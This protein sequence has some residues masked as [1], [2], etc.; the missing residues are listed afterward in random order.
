M[1]LL[2]YA[3]ERFNTGVIADV[4][5][6]GSMEDTYIISQDLGIE[7]YLKVSLF[8]VIDGHGGDYCAHYLR[9][10]LEDELRT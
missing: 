4:G 9:Q 10:R 7:D 6:R 8:A 1:G 3:C 5:Y 2:T